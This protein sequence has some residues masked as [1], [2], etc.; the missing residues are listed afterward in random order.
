MAQSTW[1]VDGKKVSDRT[2]KQRLTT[3]RVEKLER[4]RQIRL[5]MLSE[6]GDRL[7]ERELENA[8]RKADR[9]TRML[10]K[11]IEADLRKA[12]AASRRAARQQAKDQIC[13]IVMPKKGRRNSR[14]ENRSFDRMLAYKLSFS[15]KWDGLYSFH[16]KF[17][18]RGLGNRGRA[19]RAGEALRH[20]RYIMRE[21]ARE[22]AHGGIV[23]NISLDPDELAGFFAALEHLEEQDRDNANVYMSLVI[24]LPHE[25]SA[26]AREEVLIEICATFKELGLPH[27]GVLHAPDADGDQRNFHAHIMFSL[28][29][30]EIE[31]PGS[32]TFSTDKFSD[33][34]D[35]TFIEPFRHKVADILNRAMIRNN[36]ARR[37]TALSDEDRGL[38]ARSKKSGKSTPAEKHWERKDKKIQTLRAEKELHQRAAEMLRKVKSTIGQ[39]ASEPLRDFRAEAEIR[40]R[41]VLETFLRMKDDIAGAQEVRAARLAAISERVAGAQ[42]PSPSQLRRDPARRSSVAR[43]VLAL[44]RAHYPVQVRIPEGFALLSPASQL[45][46]ADRFEGE[47]SIQKAHQANWT[48]LMR[49]ITEAIERSVEPPVWE[50]E[51]GPVLVPG[52]LK[53]AQLRAAYSAVSEDQ[54]IRGLLI[55]EMARWNEKTSKKK[56]A[57]AEELLRQAQE[58]AARDAALDRVLVAH[59]QPLLAGLT[60]ERKDYETFARVLLR[61][62][63]RDELFVLPLGDQ[64]LL[65]FTQEHLRNIARDLA[66][67]PHGP[68]FLLALGMAAGEQ[69]MGV[70]CRHHLEIIPPR[71]TSSPAAGKSRQQ[72]L[73]GR[74]GL[75]R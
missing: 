47:P 51:P 36:H 68:S 14:S 39:L 50:R 27:A 48:K 28:R 18:S 74:D 72:K 16:C 7:S 58:R 24:S 46:T 15:P 37:F 2:L 29:P 6:D 4:L 59:L 69:P 40:R 12:G 34:N 19:Y 55:S 67:L 10:A 41:R 42:P 52:V 44:R 71:P 11:Q 35:A 23:S 21:L 20:L 33:L 25:L 64:R 8:V 70:T 17:T 53:D 56:K 43:A 5:T 30:C 75:G 3:A 32:Y 66:R 65:V 61:S 13:A 49:G 63:K 45:T 62:A 73:P 38:P 60:G 31:Q 9:E 57:A 54:E 1:I 26:E 22:L